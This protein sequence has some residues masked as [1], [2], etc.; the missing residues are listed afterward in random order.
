ME[1]PSYVLHRQ[2]LRAPVNGFIQGESGR[3]QLR[4]DILE[5]SLS[6]WSLGEGHHVFNQETAGGYSIGWN[7]DPFHTYGTLRLSPH[8]TEHFRTVGDFEQATLALA[9]DTLLIVGHDFVASDAQIFE[10]NESTDS[11]DLV[12]SDTVATGDAGAREAWGDSGKV[13]F[14][15]R[16][17]TIVSWNGSAFANHFSDGGWSVLAAVGGYLYAA[18]PAADSLDVKERTLETAGASTTVFKINEGKGAANSSLPLFWDAIAGSNALYIAVT[19]T[20]DETVLYRITPTTSAGAAFGEELI[21]IPGFRGIVPLFVLGT[22]FVVGY[23][24]NVP[25][26]F[27]YDET[28][29]SIGAYYRNTKRPSTHVSRPERNLQEVGGGYGAEFS[30]NHF[31]LLGGPN[32]TDGSEWTMMTLDVVS[33]GVAGGTVIDVGDLGSDPV[34]HLTSWGDLE[35]NGLGRH[36]V[37]FF[38]G[39]VFAHFQRTNDIG[40]STKGS[41]KSFKLTRG[42]Y[43]SNL[44]IMES[45]VNDFGI[46]DEKVLASITVNTEP[47]AANTRVVV[48]YQIDQD[49]TWTTAGT[50]DTDGS[51]SSTFP[52][53]TGGNTKTFRNLQIRVELDNNSTTT[54][55]PV[56]LSV[57]A[58]ATV[59]RGVRVWDLMLDTTDEDAQAQDRSWNGARLALNIAAGGDSGNVL[60][61]KDGY[62][63][64]EAAQFSTYNV[65]VDEY[66]LIGDRPGEG[67]AMVRL[68][69]V[70]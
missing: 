18:S 23:E 31:T 41:S 17:S 67:Y 14:G 12:A 55:T 59:V 70:T 69:E 7:I 44:G 33:G 19:P 39:D 45:P 16:T 29:G 60:T 54:V 42:T 10:W 52:I 36:S 9:R 26:I 28:D 51:K 6:D 2:P 22:L 1:Q 4:P 35:G 32:A 25:V 8:V 40:L 63:N 46:A 57:R 64:R 43:T 15:G 53:S 27:Y 56:V 50:H 30:K 24:G 62:Q 20:L 37:A 49:D 21:R 48:K 47:L 5:W 11:W 3:F 34:D 13:Y 65:V 61:F 38:K 58:Q 68:R 66:R